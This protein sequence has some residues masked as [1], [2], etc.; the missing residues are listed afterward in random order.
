ML[1]SRTEV[2]AMDFQCPI[3][4]GRSN[5]RSEYDYGGP[6]LS[7]RYTA[8]RISSGKKLIHQRQMNATKR[9]LILK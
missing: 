2:S 5:K 7:E 8:K 3:H 6:E 1:Y 9:N 4:S